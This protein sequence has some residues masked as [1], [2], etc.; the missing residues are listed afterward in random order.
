MRK[1]LIIADMITGN[2]NQVSNAIDAKPSTLIITSS[3]E[4]DKIIL[5]INIFPAYQNET[6][7]TNDPKNDN[8]KYRC[9]GH[10]QT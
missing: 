2:K 9:I 10:I 3:Q 7:K 5:E 8:H 6:K 1:I 4:L